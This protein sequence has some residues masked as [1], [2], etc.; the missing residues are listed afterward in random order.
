[1]K[2]CKKSKDI[3]PSNPTC[4]KLHYLL[5]KKCRGD[6]K[7]LRICETRRAKQFFSTIKFMFLQG[8]VFTR[9]VLCKTVG[10][11]FAADV[12]YHPSRQLHVQS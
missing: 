9:S 7:K 4:E 2:L 1:M 10:K 8:E 11:T 3:W 12:M 5:S 6:S